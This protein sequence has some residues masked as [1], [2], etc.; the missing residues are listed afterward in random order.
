MLHRLEHTEVALM[1]HGPDRCGGRP[2]SLHNRTDHALRHFPQRWNNDERV[3]ERVCVHGI[4]HPDPDH[5]FY[6][7]HVRRVRYDDDHDCDGC[8]GLLKDIPRRP[9]R[10]YATWAPVRQHAIW[11]VETADHCVH[12]SALNYGDDPKDP[13]VLVMNVALACRDVWTHVR[14]P[15]AAPWQG[16]QL[17]WVTLKP[18][19]GFDPKEDRRQQSDHIV[20]WNVQKP[21]TC[22]GCLACCG[23]LL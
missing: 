18:L 13:C 23:G 10:Q 14:T 2:C 4:G 20:T 11:A 1:G 9:A 3:M 19:V 7:K 15:L 16:G 6:V 22:L 8:C 21:L 17:P 12:L 5:V